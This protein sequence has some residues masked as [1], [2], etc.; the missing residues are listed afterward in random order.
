MRYL[1]SLLVIVIS[2]SVLGMRPK[3]PDR[4]IPGNFSYEDTVFYEGQTKSIHI[5]YN[6][7]NGHI[8]P[9]SKIVL[10]SVASFLKSHPK[11]SL[12]ISSHTD[13]RGNDQFNLKLSQRRAESAMNYILEQNINSEQISFRGAG[14]T[15]L[16]YS[17]DYIKKNAKTTQETEAFHQ[18]NRRTVLKITSVNYKKK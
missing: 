2:F 7:D 15:N 3:S 8:M 16:V 18:K 9:E 1:I 17:D 12:E 10:D 13:S 14:E 4:W 11:I 6:M 5:E